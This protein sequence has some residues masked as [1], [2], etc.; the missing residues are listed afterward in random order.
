MHPQ[1]FEQAYNAE[2]KVGMAT[3]ETTYNYAYILSNSSS[4]EHIRQAITLLQGERMMDDE[5]DDDDD[6]GKDGEEDE[7]EKM[8]L[9]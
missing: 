8:L 9:L 3:P 4:P 7:N 5:D 2:L 6:D 1:K